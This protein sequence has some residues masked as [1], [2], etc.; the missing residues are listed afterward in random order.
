M[1]MKSRSTLSSKINLIVYSLIIVLV[2]INVVWKGIDISRLMISQAHTRVLGITDIADARFDAWMDERLAFI[3]TIATELEFNQSYTDLNN[4]E[5]YFSNSKQNIA[6][7][8]D[9][10]LATPAKGWAHSSGWSDPSFDPTVRSW[11]ID[12]VNSNSTIITEPY[13][14]ASTGDM[15]VTLATKVSNRTGGV[16]AVLG[17]DVTLSSLKDLIDGLKESDGLY[18]FVV[19]DDFDILIHPDENYH[20]NTQRTVN[21]L[22]TN[23]ADYSNVEKAGTNTIAMANNIYGTK[24][25]AAYS[26]VGNTSWKV[27]TNYPYRYTI[28]AVITQIIIGALMMIASMVISFVI[29]RRFV[30]TYISPV[31]DV[32]NVLTEI[33]KGNLKSDVSHLAQNSVEIEMLTNSLQVVSKNLNS[34]IGE[35]SEVLTTY[36]EGDFRP[37]PTGDYVGEF[38]AIKV[39]LI[40]ISDKLKALLSDT[41]A[42]TIRVGQA[43]V[44]INHSAKELASASEVQASLLM[45]FKD[46]TTNVAT[47]IIDNIESI[48]KGYGVITDMNKKADDSKQVADEMV[49][50][51]GSIS[52]STQEILQVIKSIEEIASQTNLLALNASI[53]AARAGEAGR[54]FTIVATEVRELST[55]TSEIVQDIYTLINTSLESVETGE[56]MVSLTTKSL[57]QI[58]GASSDTANMFKAI[59][60]NALGQRDALQQIMKDTETLTTE[61]AHNAA[62]SQQNVAISEELETQADNLQTQMQNFIVK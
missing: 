49:E 25:Y 29:I 31:S 56:K 47:D 40:S 52:T 50:A 6:G 27:I 46:N 43:A 45:T 33:S 22:D 2:F 1:Q 19:S 24:V 59:R 20:P 16:G 48:D 57:E 55:K 26:E 42:S 62:I 5:G 38:N 23:K 51:M 54:G 8:I 41:T 36:S 4:L 39:S 3:N 32:A 7:V 44:D 13:I 53:E 21:L 12:A 10:Y 15:V 14:D 28:N 9:I 60:D 30:A 34:Y 17:M 11:Y 37:V 18:T 61:I 35:I 58:M